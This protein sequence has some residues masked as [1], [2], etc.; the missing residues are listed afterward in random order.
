MVA[1]VV[2]PTEPPVTIPEDPTLAIPEELLLHVPPAAASDNEVVNPEHTL[3]VPSIAVGN[4][5]T[6]TTVVIMQPVDDNA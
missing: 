3:N 1:V 2:T 4:G 6:V 5:F